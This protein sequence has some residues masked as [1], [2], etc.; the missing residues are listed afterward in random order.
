MKNKISIL[1]VSF[2]P[3]ISCIILL[4]LQKKHFGE[5]YL[6]CSAWNDEVIC[7]KIVEGTAKYGHP[8][9]YFG[10]NE[11]CAEILTFGSWSP[12]IIWPQVL[13]GYFFGW[14][15]QQPIICN[16]ALLS[17]SFFIVA[18]VLKPTLKQSIFALFMIVPFVLMSRYILSGMSEANCLISVLLFCS[19]IIALNRKQGFSI[20]LWILAN[21]ML[22]LITLMRVYYILFGMLIIA[23]IWQ[24]WTELKPILFLQFALLLAYIILSIWVSQK[25]TAPYFEPLINTEWIKLFF[26]DFAYGVR[27]FISLTENAFSELGR[28]LYSGIRNGD[29]IGGAYALFWIIGGFFLLRR[30]EHQ[31]YRV[32]F[33]IWI[34]MQLAIIYLYDIRVGSRHVLIFSYIGILVIAY[35]EIKISIIVIMF[36][37]IVLSNKG[38]T[39]DA[40]YWNLPVYNDTISA[41]IAEGR[42]QME[43]QITISDDDRWDN[44]LYYPVRDKNVI[45][46]HMLYAL[47]TGIGI[48]WGNKFDVVDNYN[49][50]KSKYIITNVDEELDE[51]IQDKNES[52]LIS[53]YGGVHVWQLR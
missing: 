47:P 28:L 45:D 51:L 4:F 25:L 15:F 16:L 46:Y 10:Y 31:L 38:I 17:I 40:Y 12:F 9:G 43:K 20:G 37:M 3:L 7:F 29:P 33:F 49:E 30:N 18:L 8:M 6:P 13:W 52:S 35:K 5:L 39:K 21:A 1:I 34:L 36:F 44:T 50:I 53:E 22:M 24:K 41:E 42:K 27:N 32:L 23:V 14:D 11:S 48:Q 19:G 2:I 26:M